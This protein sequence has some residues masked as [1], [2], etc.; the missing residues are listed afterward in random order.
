GMIVIW[1]ADFDKGSYHVCGYP[2][3]VSYSPDTT[4]KSMEFTCN[5][6]GVQTVQ[7]WVT[8][9]VLGEQDFCTTTI[10]IQDNNDA[11]DGT[12]TLTGTISGKIS[13][14]SSQDVKDASVTLSGSGLAPVTTNGTGTY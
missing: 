10:D 12:Q 5:D 4:D 2:V 11:C 8:D 1:A 9:L 7:I 13:T 3:T 14:E 6:I